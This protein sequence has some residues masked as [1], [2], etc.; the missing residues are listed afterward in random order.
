LVIEKLNTL[1]KQN[2]IE[3]QD[4]YYLRIRLEGHKWNYKRLRRVYLQ[5]VMNHRM[6][7]NNRVP[8]RIKQPLNQPLQC[9][10]S[11]SMDFMH[12]TLMNIK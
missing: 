1:T 9:I 2:P 11:W 6:R 4:I 5:L 8:A 12:D 7:T 10:E 3:G